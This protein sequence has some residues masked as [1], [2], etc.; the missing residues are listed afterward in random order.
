M[1]HLIIK[2]GNCHQRSDETVTNLFIEI[3]LNYVAKHLFFFPPV[4]HSCIIHVYL[5][6][7]NQRLNDLL[8]IKSDFFLHIWGDGIDIRAPFSSFIETKRSGQAV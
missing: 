8:Y 7:Q 2:R 1:E 3:V 6:K 4:I 5:N